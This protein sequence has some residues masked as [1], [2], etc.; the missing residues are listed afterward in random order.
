[1][2][3]LESVKFGTLVR[4]LSAVG[5]R[6]HGYELHKKT[7]LSLRYIYDILPALIEAGFLC[8][9]GHDVDEG[10]KYVSLTQKSKAF[11]NAYGSIISKKHHGVLF[12]T[13]LLDLDG[14]I[15]QR[16]WNDPSNDACSVSTWDVLF[17]RLNAY[18][19]HERL[20]R[21]F[22]NGTFKS[23]NEWTNEA[24]R[25]L[26]AKGLNRQIFYE[27][28]KSRKY[29]RGVKQTLETLL[30]NGVVVG[31]ITGSF[32]ELAERVKEDFGFD[33]AIHAHCRLEF[34]EDGKLLENGWEISQ[35]DYEGKATFLKEF[36]KTL[37][38]SLDKIAYVGDDVNDIAI[39]KKVGLAIAFNPTKDKVRKSAKVVI[40]GKDLRRILPCLLTEPLLKE[41]MQT[42]TVSASS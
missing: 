26:Y 12:P 3:D 14:V 27:V 18:D 25:V 11:V 6:S 37:K 13:T 7:G 31:V 1:M 36:G 41:A 34:D 9:A 22:M 35:T 16:P 5:Q 38:T 32:Y 15:F 28:I 20:K 10:R 29:N 40:E 33:I 17:K 39:F 30:A 8:D 2:A 23:Y 24:C 19:E 42:R 21:K 4:L